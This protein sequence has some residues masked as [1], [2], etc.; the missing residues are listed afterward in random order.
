MPEKPAITGAEMV[1]RRPVFGGDKPVFG[2]A[3]VTG[4][5]IGAVEAGT[6]EIGLCTTESELGRLHDQASQRR[7]HDI[8]ATMLRIDEV[9]AGKDIAIVFE[10]EST[11]TLLGVHAETRAESEPSTERHVEGL[12][13]D[14]TDVGSQPAIENRAKKGAVFLGIDGFCRDTR[15]VRGS[16]GRLDE[17]DKLQKLCAGVLEKSIHDIGVVDIGR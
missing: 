8:A 5:T 11:A 15:T 7:F 6:R 3:A 1:E 16:G 9:V 12:Y 14:P 13:V 17:R 2:A 10:G 4:E